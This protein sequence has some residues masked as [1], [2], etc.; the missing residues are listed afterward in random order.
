MPSLKLYSVFHCNLAF[1]S[2][3][4]A[5]YPAVIE[6]CYR[7]I[8]GLCEAGYPLGIEMTAWT[9]KAA[10]AIDPGFVERLKRLWD[11]G[12]CEFIGSGYS[13][14]I[15]PLI[16]AE[17]NRWN[18]EAGNRWYERM[19]GRRPRIALVN[20]QT[21]SRGLPD[22]YRE[23]GYETI[24]MDWDNSFQHNRYPKEYKYYPQ[25]AAGIKGG[26]NVL[27]S[28]SIAFQ[29]FQRCIHGEI[30]MEEYLAYIASH[31]G[32]GAQRAFGL[33]TNDAEVFDYRPGQDTAP[34]S[35]YA[36]MA[37]LLGKIAS[38]AD[39][40]IA[41]LSA[42]IEGFR[43]HSSAFNRISLESVETPVVC[44]KQEKYNPA[45]WAVAG[46]DSVHLNSECYR[47]YDNIR[48]LEEGGRVDD[49][50]LRVFKETLCDLWGSDFRTNTID[51]KFLYFQNRM[52]WLTIET[53]R[54]LEKLPLNKCHKNNRLEINVD[55]G[56]E[57]F[58]SSA[59]ALSA[60]PA[61]RAARE[62][63]GA[64]DI[65]SAVIKRGVHTLS[66]STGQVD[67]EFLTNKGCAIRSA[68]FPAV[69]PR[70][71]IGTLA[72]GYYDDISLGADFF[73]G[74]L[75]HMA[76]DGRKTTDMRDVEPSVAETSE[77]VIV[78]AR[79]P[80]EIGTLWKSYEVMKAT[81]EIRVSYRLKVNG[82]LASSLRLGIFTVMPEGFDINSL[83]LETVNG[84]LGAERFYLKGHEISHDEPVSQSVS[85]SSCLGATEGWVRIG[86]ASRAIEF[87]SDKSR[88]F[89]VPMV[90]YRGVGS[91]E[92]FFLRLYHSLGEV[93]DTAWW[94]WRGYNDIAF[95]IKALKMK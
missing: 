87:S 80:L 21:Y 95:T 48:R 81:P 30:A 6:R 86:D 91:G 52:G 82:L 51:E 19:L 40:E 18:L 79:I 37:G 77:S 69:S 10:N 67:I 57:L 3:P 9:L 27:W 44:K 68:A 34:S 24:I 66:V 63:A 49:E 5:D 61:G 92:T 8:L 46:R 45:R 75:I 93:D 31:A 60:H 84:G 15:F 88:L 36:F 64:A 33:Y 14:A 73:T 1:S 28:H 74:H 53:E 41:P 20:E 58:K 43:G 23:A 13:Q 50:T 22:I 35:E 16:P 70:P 65:S 11:E 17:V 32:G 29:K 12:G 38:N 7:P 54:L 89:S 72:H 78:A 90:R 39:I 76:R 4:E 56:C 2:I 25:T 47:A 85:A 55:K 83:W 62:S 26:I 59:A 94:V 71:L 42:V